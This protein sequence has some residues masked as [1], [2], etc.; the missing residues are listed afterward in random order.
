MQQVVRRH[1]LGEAFWAQEQAKR[2]TM[3]SSMGRGLN[4]FEIL[5]GVDLDGLD[6]DAETFAAKMKKAQNQQQEFTQSLTLSAPDSRARK[7]TEKYAPGREN[8]P[9]TVK[10]K[11]KQK[12]SS[13]KQRKKHKKHKSKSKKR[14]TPKKPQASEYV[15]R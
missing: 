2:I 8:D 14:K 10:Q 7:I 6:V 4:I 15:R 5:S 12:S 1:V 9:Y 11:K 3:D 13:D